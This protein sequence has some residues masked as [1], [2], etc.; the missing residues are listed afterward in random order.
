MN[1][2][3]AAVTQ[4]TPITTAE[5]AASAIDRLNAIMDRLAESHGGKPPW[6]AFEEV[7]VA[8]LARSLGCPAREVSGHASLLD[9][10]DD[11]VPTLADR[12]E[13]LVLQ[14]R[15]EADPTFQP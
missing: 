14:V 8:G 9:A 1:Q 11:I 4:P 6:P 7:D 15:V 12:T 5:E 3:A 10:L 13:P 2:Q